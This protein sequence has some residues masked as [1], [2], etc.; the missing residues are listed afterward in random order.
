MRCMRIIKPAEK[1]EN[2]D[3]DKRKDKYDHKY[4]E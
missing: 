3:F 4:R 2:N 1:S